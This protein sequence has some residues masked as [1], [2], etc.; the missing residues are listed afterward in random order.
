MKSTAQ[1]DRYTSLAAIK[2]AA[3]PS[4]LID[5]LISNAWP[6]SV[7]NFSSVSLPGP[8][9]ATSGVPHLN[10]V[11]RRTKPRYHFSAGGG[12]PPRFWEREPFVWDDE[13]GRVSRFVS[14]GSF[15]GEPVDGKKQRV[16]MLSF[17]L[18][19]LNSLIAS[20]VVLCIFHCS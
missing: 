2:S 5:I 16:R 9:L 4:Q 19:P 13:G 10:D 7:I 12:K 3:A 6:S 11:I 17:L 8:D 14:L 15:G 18:I 20:Q 1:K